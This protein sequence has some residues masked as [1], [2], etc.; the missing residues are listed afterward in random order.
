MRV[1]RHKQET[2]VTQLQHL[3]S[4]IVIYHLDALHVFSILYIIYVILLCGH[5]HLV[6]DE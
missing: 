4:F 2:S 5:K 6:K 3:D 1:K